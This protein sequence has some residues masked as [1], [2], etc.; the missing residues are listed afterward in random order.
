MSLDVSVYVCGWHTPNGTWVLFQSE[1]RQS[2]RERTGANERERERAYHVILNHHVL[3]PQYCR[4]FCGM[5]NIHPNAICCNLVILHGRLFPINASH[6]ANAHK[7]FHSLCSPLYDT[8]K[9]KVS[10]VAFIVIIIARDESKRICTIFFSF[11]PVFTV[12][13][14]NAFTSI[15]CEH[16]SNK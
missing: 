2:E 7:F 13:V 4:I 6:T 15:C 11:V 16:N 8:R 5:F 3:S 1:K 12:F 10:I 14:P 9:K